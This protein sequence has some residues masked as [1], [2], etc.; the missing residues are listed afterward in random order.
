MQV[1]LDAW[2]AATD[3]RVTVQGLS[4]PP[5]YA[6]VS[7]QQL[8]HGDALPPVRL[9]SPALTDLPAGPDRT[10]ACLDRAL[11]LVEDERGRYV[12]FVRGPE[13]HEEPAVFLEVAG[14]P[15][16]DAQHVF[17]EL[18]DL[19]NRHNVYRGQVVELVFGRSGPTRAFPVLPTTTRD[20]VVLPDVVLRRIERHTLD[21]A[22]H[23][24]VLRAAG[25]HLKRGVLLYGPPGTGKT[26]TT[27]YV[28]QQLAGTTVLLLSGPA[29]HAVE[30]VSQLARELQPAVLVLEDVDLVAEDRAH[31]PRPIPCCSPS[32]T[33]WTVPPAT[34]PC[35]SC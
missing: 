3:R 16:S 6:G 22:R 23:R 20:D 10:V 14:L 4:A 18:S 35:S 33:P 15:T 11:L 7:L 5:Q 29:L 27:R 12:L 9:S 30:V 24:A 19:Q 17:R 13:R 25:Q 31:G 32:S 21:V 8:V 26:H 1:A 34:P 28:V 2:R